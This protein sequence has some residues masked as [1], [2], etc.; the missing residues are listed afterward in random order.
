MAIID[1][2]KLEVRSDGTYVRD[3]IFVE[4]VADGYIFLLKNM[5][6]ARRTGI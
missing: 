3:Y 2:K 6:K 1:K 5:D 4:D